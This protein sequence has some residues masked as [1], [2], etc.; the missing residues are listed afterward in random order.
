MYKNVIFN[1]TLT[2]RLFSGDIQ[3]IL[4]KPLTLP[5]SETTVLTSTSKNLT[6]NQHMIIT[7]LCI[8][9][10]F[11]VSNFSTIMS[12]IDN[13]QNCHLSSMLPPVQNT[14]HLEVAKLYLLRARPR[15]PQNQSKIHSMLSQFALNLSYSSTL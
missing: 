13:M 3:P 7:V 5:L 2:D 6:W 1:L 10:I 8:N 15:V 12:H 9:D 4:L 14:G 11:P